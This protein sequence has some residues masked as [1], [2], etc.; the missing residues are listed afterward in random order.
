[1]RCIY[2]IEF[3]FGDAVAVVRVAV[4]VGVVVVFVVYSTVFRFS[5]FLFH[6]TTC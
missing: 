1:M 4:D 6:F 3:I 2:D 5:P